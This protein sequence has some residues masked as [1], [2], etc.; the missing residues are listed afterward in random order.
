[1][2][3]MMI[4]ATAI[5]AMA[6]AGCQ[7]EQQQAPVQ[8]ESTTL[9][10]GLGDATKATHTAAV[11]LLWAEGDDI[12]VD[13]PLGFK[14]F[15]LVSGEGTASGT[16]QINETVTV[17][18]NATAVYPAALAPSWSDDKL[19]MTLPDSYAW[20]AHGVQAPMISWVNNAYPYFHLLGG[21][22]KLDVYNIPESSTKLVF[23]TDGQNVS[24]D[25]VMNGSNAIETSAGTNN[26]VTITFAA[27]TAANMTFFVPVPAGTYTN[28]TFSLQ[29]T[30]EALKTV[31]A[32]SITVAKDQ[33]F[34]APAL[35]C[36]GAAATTLVSD[37][38]DCTDWS[39]WNQKDGLALTTVKAGDRLRFHLTEGSTTYWQVRASYAADADW[40]WADMPTIGLASGQ[41][42]ADVILTED[43]ASCLRARNSLV[44][45][46][47]GV[48]VNSMEY[49]PAVEQI[50]WEGSHS[51]G[52]WDNAFNYQGL[53]SAAL[54]A[55][56]KA[57]KELDV[58]F[59]ESPLP[60]IDYCQFFI[61]KASDW[62]SIDG[63]SFN[64]GTNTNQKVMAFPLTAAQVTAIKES[65]I[66]ICGKK[67]TIT[68][69]TLR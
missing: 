36:D 34:F 25:F 15:D 39:N 33:L 53:N 55:G 59:E 26:T 29:S 9:H 51:L 62:S 11:Q 68:K 46:G 31:K 3:K 7:K 4:L 32:A 18:E 54:W 63:L 52:D 6:L 13:T 24:G 57:G 30:S 22:I 19:T 64:A 21:L 49:I 14:T 47:Y 2:K 20:T 66:V 67:I 41:T 12:S 1:M 10:F 48:T 56:L 8:E 27:G 35:N 23:T 58:Y 16:F 44:V 17:N 38:L 42:M 37:A 43:V 5:A 60:A 40:H 28:C 61:Q 69:I 45:T 50:L 65:G